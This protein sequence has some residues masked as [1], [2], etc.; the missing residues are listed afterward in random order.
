MTYAVMIVD[1]AVPAGAVT[2][3]P[4]TS[5][6]LG[7]VHPDDLDRAIGWIRECDSSDVLV[8]ARPRQARAAHTV[9]T[10]VTGVHPRLAAHVALREST[11]LAMAI[12]AS[13]SL[14]IDAPA[15]LAYATALAAL[16]GSL[17]G[18]HLGR[19]SK[20][21]SPSPSIW[22]HLTSLFGRRHIAVR[23]TPGRVMRE[24]ATIE[25]PA[26]GTRLVATDEGSPA[27]TAVVAA[28]DFHGAVHAVPPVIETTASFGS[29][30]TEFVVF[31]APWAPPA[32]WTC[33]VCHQ[34]LSGSVCPF[35]RVR[36]T[37]QEHV[38]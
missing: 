2:H 20:V 22:Q 19:L 37:H 26:D 33:A 14:E 10:T 11:V 9:A 38:A 18:A 15:P 31:A 28:L 7:L 13:H 36:S 32:A 12:A 8:L 30:G 6:D 3:W 5:G 4:M 35:C 23:G 24:G 16:D 34:S 27:F 17:V 25:V 21:E 29:T 1:A